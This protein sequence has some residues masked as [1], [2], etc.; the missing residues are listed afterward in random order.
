MSEIKELT[1]EDVELWLNDR[2][3]QHVAVSV[4]WNGEEML[5]AVGGELQSKAGEAARRAP[6]AAAPWLEAG[7]FGG[8]YIVGGV[9]VLNLRR[10]LI[11][12]AVGTD[13]DLLIPVRQDLAIKVTWPGPDELPA[14]GW[15]GDGEED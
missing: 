3:G 10:P 4:V 12:P 14:G 13:S 2:L 8:V 5:L 6:V 11:S 15:L 9:A 1:L 7:V